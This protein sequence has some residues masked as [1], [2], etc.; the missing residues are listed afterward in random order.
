MTENKTELLP[1]PFEKLILMIDRVAG[2][3]NGQWSEDILQDIRSGLL[4]LKDNTIAPLP[5]DKAAALEAVDRVDRTL[6]S[7]MQIIGLHK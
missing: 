4:E 1:C 5:S 3:T 7:F 6:N 2:T